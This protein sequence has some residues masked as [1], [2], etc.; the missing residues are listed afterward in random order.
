VSD[1]LMP[2][3]DG[4]EFA[5]RLWRL[6]IPP[7]LVFCSAHL[8]DKDAQRIVS[9]LGGLE[10]LR[11]P[12][13]SEASQKVLATAV[14][15]SPPEPPIYPAGAGIIDDLVDLAKIESGTME[16][17]MEPV[18]VGSV[19][20]EVRVTVQAQAEEKGLALDV[21]V[22][23]EMSCLADRQAMCQIVLQLA[24]NAIKF[25]D[26]GTVRVY[27][28]AA[29]EPGAVRIDVIDKGR[30]ISE[31]D[32]LT[33]FEP[34]ER[35]PGGAPGRTGTGLGWHLSR[36]R[37]ALLGAHITIESEPGHGSTFSLIVPGRT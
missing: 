27:A 31:A 17:N 2:R 21:D 37:A 11:K 4:F 28:A 33:L 15:A 5:R 7:R 23:K 9:R 20:E 19:V 16:L 29:D 1:V 25:R 26:A 24:N 22:S 6:G 36:K 14:A 8:V 10:L 3:M 13:E 35:S 34:L 12:V 30:G 32:R 18:D